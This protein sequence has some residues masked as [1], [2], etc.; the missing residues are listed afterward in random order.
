[1]TVKLDGAHLSPSRA[2]Q[3]PGLRTTP[4]QRSVGLGKASA[5]WSSERGL[6]RVLLA[7]GM[8]PR[9]SSR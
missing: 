2:S 9:A 7:G 4:P 3:L 6:A 5:F 1:M 8:E